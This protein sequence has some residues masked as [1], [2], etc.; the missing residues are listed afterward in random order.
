MLSSLVFVV[1]CV[2]GVGIF[3]GMCFFEGVELMIFGLYVVVFGIFSVV[4]VFGRNWIGGW[5]LKFFVDIS[6]FL[7][8]VYVLIGYVVLCVLIGN[9]WFGFVVFVVVVLV[10][11]LL[12]WV[13]YVFIECLI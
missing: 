7:Y 11:I 6:F 5:L 12:V 1:F 9:G 4:Y 8:V 13:M 2:G 10:V 3:V